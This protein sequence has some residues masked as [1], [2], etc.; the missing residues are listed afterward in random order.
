MKLIKSI[1]QFLGFCVIVGGVFWFSWECSKL[2]HKY[3]KPFTPKK[4]V[5]ERLIAIQEDVGARPDGKI[6]PETTRLV[7]AQCELE[8]PEY[9]NKQA[10]PYFTQSGSPKEK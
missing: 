7:N 1:I 4:L 3:Q 10:K 5:I 9:F 2:A 6:G 8:K